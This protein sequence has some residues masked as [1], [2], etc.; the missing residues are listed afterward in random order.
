[1]RSLLFSSTIVSCLLFPAHVATAVETS[2][3][4]EGEYVMADGDTLALAEERVLQ[5]A[6]R[7]AVEE[8]GLYLESVFVDSEKS[9][10]GRNF[11]STALE[12]RTI[13]AAITKT[14][15]LASRRSFEHDRPTFYIKIRAQ[16]DLEHLAEA[17]RRW[18]A[19]EQLAL[20]FRALQ[21]ENMHLKA[22]LQDLRA[23]P[24]GVTMLPIG[25]PIPIRSAE[26]ARTLVERAVQSRDLRHKLDLSSQA[27]ELDPQSATPLVVRGQ[28]YLGLVSIAY[29]DRLPATEYSM[30]VDNAR[31][32]FDRALLIDA[33]NTWALLGQGD[34][35]TWLERPNAAAAAYEEALRLDPFFD[36]A[37]QRLI[38]LHTTQ[39]RKLMNVNEQLPALAV[40]DKLLDSYVPPSWILAAKEAFVLRSQVYQR[41]N[42]PTQAIDNLNMVLQVDP[43]DASA[44]LARGKL[45]QQGLQGIP[46]KDDFEHACLLGSVEACQQLP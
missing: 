4:A 23:R 45:R 42:Q 32:D 25:P 15:I 16:V 5:R 8:A 22:Q 38:N 39:A 18:K 29:R 17:V 28:T 3:V 20:H 33:Q 35:N 19:D 21:K 10:A 27:A 24:A 40:L 46:A 44:L 30:Y 7:R 1:M 2:I 13:A 14:V 43:S 6:Q 26:Q 37:R 11:Q 31:M 41:L 34:A 12:I 36:V 9:L